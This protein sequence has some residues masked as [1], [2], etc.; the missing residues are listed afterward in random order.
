MNTSSIPSSTGQTEAF[1]P[2]RPVNEDE[3][4]AIVAKADDYGATSKIKMSG[5]NYKLYTVTVNHKE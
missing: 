5:K 3:K 2:T 1:Y 4:G